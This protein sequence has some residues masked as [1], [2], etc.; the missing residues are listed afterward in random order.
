MRSLIS[1][2]WRQSWGVGGVATPDF[3][4]GV[5]DPPAHRGSQRGWW[6]VVDGS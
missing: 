3:G 6:G 5:L 1:I 2:Q 4:Q